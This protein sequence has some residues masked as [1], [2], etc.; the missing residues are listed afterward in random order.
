VQASSIFAGT[1]NAR[2]LTPFA[3]VF[4]RYGR[5]VLDARRGA[6]PLSRG[7]VGGP[8]KDAGGTVTR[9]GGDALRLRGACAIGPGRCAMRGDTP[10]MKIGEHWPGA[11]C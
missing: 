4:L 6:A 9:M 2:K 3:A 5:K 7:R 11:A 1:R 8:H 10:T